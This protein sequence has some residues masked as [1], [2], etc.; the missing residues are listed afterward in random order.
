VDDNLGTE[1]TASQLFSAFGLEEACC[2]IQEGACERGLRQ[3][4]EPFL[5]RGATSMQAI[6]PAGNAGCRRSLGADRGGVF[7]GDLKAEQPGVIAGCSSYS[8][9]IELPSS[10]P[11]LL[12][13][14]TLKVMSTM[15][16]QQA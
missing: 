8:R 15:S 7:R 5:F 2:C 10:T 1:R 4:A 3:S 9:W 12:A 13:E 16:Y 11:A 14:P 6:G